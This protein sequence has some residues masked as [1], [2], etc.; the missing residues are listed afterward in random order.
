MP[1]PQPGDRRLDDGKVYSFVQD[2]QL[3]PVT[4][5]E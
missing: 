5:E 4:C 1:A 3:Q 2:L